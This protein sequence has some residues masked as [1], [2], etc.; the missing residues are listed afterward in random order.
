MLAAL[1]LVF[2]ATRADC[3]V[4]TEK[5]QF[6]IFGGNVPIVID[7]PALDV[8]QNGKRCAQQTSLQSPC[9][10]TDVVCSDG[11]SYCQEQ[12]QTRYDQVCVTAKH[13]YNPTRC[14]V[15]DDNIKCRLRAVPPPP[16]EDIYQIECYDSVV[17]KCNNYL[18]NQQPPQWVCECTSGTATRTVSYTRKCYN[19]AYP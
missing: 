7:D 2:C 13:Y 14:G 11:L 8:W 12:P 1:F 4:L 6:A 19:E 9:Y 16:F 3:R 17:C 15:D 18:D 10:K 5:E